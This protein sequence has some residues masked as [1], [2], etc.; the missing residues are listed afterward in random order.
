MRKF[1]IVLSVAFLFSCGTSKKNTAIYSEDRILEE[2]VKNLDKNPSDTSL[3]NSMHTL[4]KGAAQNHLYNIELYETMTEPGR[5][6]KIIAEYNALQRLNTI[7]NHSAAARIVVKPE[8]YTAKI[9]IVKQHAAADNY[10]I[11]MNLMEENNG[12]LSFREA[13]VFLKKANGYVPGY[14]DAARQMEIAWENG[15]MDIIVDPVRI[16]D[17]YA[18]QG[19][20]NRTMNQFNGQLLQNDLVRDLGGDFSRNSYARYYTNSQAR[21]ARINPDWLIDLSWVQL[22]IPQPSVDRSTKSINKKIETGKDSTGRPVYQK[23]TAEL[24]II[25]QKVNATGN[26]EFR[27][28][29]AFNRME[30]HNQRHSAR[31]PWDNKYATFTGDSRALSDV[32]RALVNNKNS[33]EPRKDEMVHKLY[34]NVYSQIKNSIERLVKTAK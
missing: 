12:K 26:L 10:E 19:D 32:D 18:L 22:N 21:N 27:I 7:I 29:D 31:A 13:F 16:D 14:K 17:R 6:D 24:T 5:W 30:V 11:G 2:A 23:V 9:D 3:A 25:N 8:S 15:I 1:L 33:T 34:Q 28:T 20:W 4:Y